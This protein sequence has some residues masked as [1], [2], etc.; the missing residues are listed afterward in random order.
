[1]KELNINSLLNLELINKA[2]IYVYSNQSSIRLNYTCQFIFNHVLKCNYLICTSIN[3]FENYSGPKINYSLNYNNKSINIPVHNF[4]ENV[5]PINNK[6]KIEID[7]ANEFILFKNEIKNF[8]FNF[9]LF[10]AV[11]ACISRYEEWINTKFDSHNRFEIESSLFYKNNYHLQPI[12]DEWIIHLKELIEKIFKCNLNTNSFKQICTIDIDNLYA[13]K[14]K[15]FVR[16]I[17]GAV[18]DLFQ[19]KINLIIQR[20]SVCLN[21][22]KDPFDVYDELIKHLSNSKID[23]LFFYLLHTGNKFD[24]TL[25]PLN[26]AFKENIKKIS[27]LALTGLHP[28]YYSSTNNEF[29]NNEVNLYKTLTG[30]E[31]EIS[32]QH[33]LKFDIKST[34]NLLHSK[35]IKADFTMGFASKAGFRAG[36]SFPFYYFDFKT[37]LPLSLLAV[38]F[39]AMDGAYIIYE[40]T[41]QEEALIQLKHLK[42]KVKSVGGL[43]I[44]VFHERTFS[45]THYKN[46]SELFYKIYN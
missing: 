15:G 41:K 7:N 43:F 21:I 44:T 35:G 13:F 22:T 10:S 32:R 9:D 8:D 20:I 24:R 19:L 4:L 17:G 42:E 30:K 33:Y 38:P 12:V 27:E 46:A 34:P 36:T 16:N 37:N 31:V 45:K 3:E 25:S 14:H 39:C 26:K 5:C 11:F 29:L 18:K 40:T 28:S 2:T 23:V 6:L 1:L